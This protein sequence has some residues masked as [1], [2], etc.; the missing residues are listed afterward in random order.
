MQAHIRFGPAG[1]LSQIFIHLVEEAVEGTREHK[2]SEDKG[3][4]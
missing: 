3:Q 4:K 2:L 1:L